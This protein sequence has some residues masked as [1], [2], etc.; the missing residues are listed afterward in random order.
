MKVHE[1]AFD[2]KM[3]ATIRVNADSEAEA[4]AILAEKINCASCN[5]GAWANGD[6]ILFEASIDDYE[7]GCLIEVDGEAA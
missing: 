6:P 5:A 1:Y 4:R 7:G 3:F 2:V